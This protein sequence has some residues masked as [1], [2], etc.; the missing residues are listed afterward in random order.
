MSNSKSVERSDSAERSPELG[1][2]F[3][4]TARTQLLSDSSFFEEKQRVSTWKIGWR[5]PTF[6]CAFYVSAAALALGHFLFAWNLNGKAVPLDGILRQSYVSAFS[7]AFALGFRSMLTASLSTAFIQR[8]WTL[9]RSKPMKASTIDTLLSLVQ[10]PLKLLHFDVLWSARLEWIFA[11]CCL[12]IPI[13]T[14]FPPGALTVELKERRWAKT[15]Q[16]PTF[17]PTSSLTD[18]LAFYIPFEQE[19]ATPRQEIIRVG[20]RS[21]AAGSYV[22]GPS[23]CGQNCTY[24][25][26]FQGPILACS[27]TTSYQNLS[28]D[29]IY[30]DYTAQ[31]GDYRAAG[32]L[33]VGNF[34]FE[35]HYYQEVDLDHQFDPQLFLTCFLN[36]AD[37]FVN[38]TYISGNPVFDYQVNNSQPINSTALLRPGNPNNPQPGIPDANNG[39]AITNLNVWAIYQA[40]VVAMTGDVG[41][42]GEYDQLVNDTMVLE[43]SLVQYIFET[44]TKFEGLIFNISE[45]SLNSMLH[46]ITLS[47]ISL[48][49]WNTSTEVITGDFVNTYSFTG[50]RRYNLI[51]PYA[52][53]L[54]VSLGFVVLGLYSLFG[55]SV[56]AS[57]GFL[58]TIQTS[59]GSV[60]LDAAA[61]G[62]SLGGPDNVPKELQSLELVF[63][64]LTEPDGKYGAVRRAGWGTRSEIRPLVKGAYYDG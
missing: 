55:N 9:F 46:N 15:T 10:T 39:A 31:G 34:D 36:K 33:A 19:Y 50:H 57:N 6:I 41:R 47:T 5:T 51:M 13:A 22:T 1:K 20:K 54:L 4:N 61:K 42:Y 37:Y 24:T 12:C 59:G 3:T 32:G 45:T 21:I 29:A 44:G 30:S 58:Q 52:V 11:L 28:L 14:V 35:V 25:I 53:C 26:T 43:S 48:G 38:V 17:I 23:P 62:S 18:N 7:I 2:D 16:V 56:A 8:L 49:L 40:M 64:E 63:G 27:N 60:A